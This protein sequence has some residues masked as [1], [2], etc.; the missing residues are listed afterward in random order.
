MIFLAR[1]IGGLQLYRRRTICAEHIEKI[2]QNIFPHASVVG[3]IGVPYLWHRQVTDKLVRTPNMVV[4]CVYRDCR[5][6]AGHI[7][8]R[9]RYRSS[10]AESPWVNRNMRTLED[11]AKK[12]VW[13]M[14]GMEQYS[15]QIHTIRYEDLVTDPQAVITELSALLPVDPE[16]FDYQKIHAKEVGTYK[17]WLSDDEIATI[18]TIAGPTMERLGYTI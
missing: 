2:L 12:W 16:G 17:Q 7:V 1:F 13:V 8:Y 10:W 6:V 18:L 4:T 9:N 5:D 15:S 11:V 14:E 3:D